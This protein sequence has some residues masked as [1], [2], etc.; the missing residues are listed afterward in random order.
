M[1]AVPTILQVGDEARAW[2]RH[3]RSTVGAGATHS[4][5]LSSQRHIVVLSD[6]DVTPMF[7]PMD[8]FFTLFRWRA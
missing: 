2:A 6:A 8:G 5:P 7:S 1:F 3:C 4:S